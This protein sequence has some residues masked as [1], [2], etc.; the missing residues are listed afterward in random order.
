MQTLL[1]G[2]IR[3]AF[4]AY[5]IYLETDFKVTKATLSFPFSVAQAEAGG[6][7]GP[8]Q[9]WLLLHV[10]P[11]RVMRTGIVIISIGL[12]L[13]SLAP[14]LTLLFAAVIIM[15]LGIGLAGY[16]TLNTVVAHWF[17]LK[18]TT[19][20]GFVGA[21]MGVG[22]LLLPLVAFSLGQLG[23][24]LTAGL[25]AAL[26]LTLGLGIAQ[27]IRGKPEDYGLIPDGGKSAELT[28]GLEVPKEAKNSALET[29]APSLFTTREALQTS[30]FWLLALGHALG[31]MAA[32]SLTLHMIPHL[33]NRLQVS[34]EAAATLAAVIPVLTI[35]SQVAGGYLGDKMNKRLLAA[36]C[37]LGHAVALVILATGAALPMIL[38][39][40]VI[41]AL[42]Q[43]IRGPLMPSIRADYFGRRGFATVMGISLFIVMAG[44][45]TG[46]VLVGYLADQ[47]GDYRNA[48]FVIAA[49]SALGSMMF[50]LARRPT[51][52]RHFVVVA[53]G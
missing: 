5:F 29:A 53:P 18:R 51:P 34:L 20:M 15:G 49:F 47:F 12:L 46:P 26:V 38:L 13:M 43:G 27:I 23:W 50:L 7:L 16:L 41:H 14:N 24:R 48:F 1:G 2:V 6:L 22:G 36:F 4:G 8:V 32:S 40:S 37:M 10:G 52:P 31:V 39:A 9:G 11:R 42:A 19:A 44:T 45:L 35:F 21:G 28:S 3:H 33:I 17:D 30:A 25:S